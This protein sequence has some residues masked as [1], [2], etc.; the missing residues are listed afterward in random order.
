L[1]E[2]I[3]GVSNQQS[4][5][6]NTKIALIIFGFAFFLSC[7]SNQT[8]SDTKAFSFV[9]DSVKIDSLSQMIQKNPRTANL[10]SQRA[11]LLL[12]KGNLT[13]AMLDLK[14]ANQLDSLNPE[15]YC[16][17]ADYFLQ[18]GKSEMVNKI[19]L[20][21][22]KLIPQNRDILYRLGNLNFYIQDYRKAMDYLNQANEVD[23]FYAPAF[24]SK[25]L[26]FKETGDTARA[27]ISFQIA[28]EREPDYYDAYMQLGL[29]YAEQND[30]LAIAYYNN[31]LRIIPDSYEAQYARAMFYQQSKQFEQAIQ[32]YK[33]MLTEQSGNLPF[34]HYNLGY[35]EMVY[36]G[37]YIEAKARFDTTLMI[38][39]YPEA[40][41]NRGFCAEKLGDTSAAL[42]DYKQALASNPKFELAQKGLARLNK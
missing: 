30:S 4:I 17:L 1:H 14:M 10:Y 24:F 22:D 8:Q 2:Q 13:Q 40:L 27:I 29:L 38:K 9:P 37:N 41:Y 33:Q 28:V 25:A 15:Y 32:H 21:G 42:A 20:K 35:I 3:Q 6:M 26:I 23:R 36:Y 7:Q 16:Q 12:A 5:A 11:Q 19:L 34:V 18:L 39:Q 31:A